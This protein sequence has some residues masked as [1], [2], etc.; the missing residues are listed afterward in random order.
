MR[1]AQVAAVS[2]LPG[3]ASPARETQ[4]L[5]P[6][7]QAAGSCQT[8]CREGV[9]LKDRQEILSDL[10]DSQRACLRDQW[11]SLGAN[12]NRLRWT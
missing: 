10:A 12:R 11:R 8:L 7:T 5:P 1:K 3:H 9:A 4:R 2:R 6:S